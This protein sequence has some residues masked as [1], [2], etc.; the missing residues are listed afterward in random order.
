M[1]LTD[2]VD[3]LNQYPSDSKIHQVSLTV[4]AITSKEDKILGLIDITKTVEENQNVQKS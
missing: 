3:L 1:R 4:Y 2:F